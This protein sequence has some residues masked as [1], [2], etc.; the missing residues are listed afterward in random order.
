MR[1]SR[2]RLAVALLA[3]QVLLL[4]GSPAATTASAPGCPRGPVT[5]Q[6]LID[7]ERPPGPLAAEFP[8][9]VGFINERALDCFRRRTLHLRAFVNRVEG[10]GGA[11]AYTIAPQWLWSPRLFVFT[12]DRE[13]APGF[14]DGPWT[15]VYAPPGLGDLQARYARQWVTLTGHFRDRRATTCRAVG[16][17]GATP[18]SA[19]TIRMCQA[20]FVVSAVE[21]RAVSA[22]ARESKRPGR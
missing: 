14:G 21:A 12:T 2:A 10:L 5:L 8:P 20:A 17:P 22:G 16:V 18:D 6:D 3:M 1:R 13:L 7:L 11:S 9:A 4:A 15:G 19:Q